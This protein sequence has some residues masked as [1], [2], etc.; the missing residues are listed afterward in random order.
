MAFKILDRDYKHDESGEKITG[1]VCSIYCDSA[2]DLP[3]AEDITTEN[4]LSGS[5]AWLGTERNFKTLST[6]KEWI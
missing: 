3:T 2:D 1:A 4:I 6:E 5:W